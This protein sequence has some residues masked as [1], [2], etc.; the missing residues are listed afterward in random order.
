MSCLVRL[1]PLVR[2]RV[3]TLSRYSGLVWFNSSPVYSTG[4]SIIQDPSFN[5]SRLWLSAQKKIKIRL[6]YFLRNFSESFRVLYTECSE[7][8]F[9]K[10]E[11]SY[12]VLFSI[13]FVL[14][15]VLNWILRARRR[16]D[17]VNCHDGAS[18][19]NLLT[20]KLSCIYCCV[21]AIP[22]PPMGRDNP[23]PHLIQRC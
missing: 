5:Y 16:L 17:C 20:H 1:R 13:I 11:T 19:W 22:R 4:K 18:R 7:K 9:W 2:N 8:T 3:V 23:S 21:F 15:H 6:V 12:I 14:L 10:L